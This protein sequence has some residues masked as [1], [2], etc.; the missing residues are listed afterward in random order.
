MTRP[1]RPT[2]T[3]FVSLARHLEQIGFKPADD[4]EEDDGEDSYD[5]H[6]RRESACVRQL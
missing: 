5:E 2:L 4:V 6:V 3:S 1:L